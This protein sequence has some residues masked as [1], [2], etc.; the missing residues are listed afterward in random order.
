MH[1]LAMVGVLKLLVRCG[2]PLETLSSY[3]LMPLK[4]IVPFAHVPDVKEV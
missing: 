4:D 3:Q 1:Q 2:L